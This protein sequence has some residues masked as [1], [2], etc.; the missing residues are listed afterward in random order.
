MKVLLE[1]LP[2]RRAYQPVAVG[3]ILQLLAEKVEASDVTHM[4]W[5]RVLLRNNLARW[6]GQQEVGTGIRAVLSALEG[7]DINEP[8]V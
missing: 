3:E 8:R 2:L 5:L 6:E 4:S 7:M 1:D